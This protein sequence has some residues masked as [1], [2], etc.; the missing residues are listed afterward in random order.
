VHGQRYLVVTA[1]DYGIG[2][3]TSQGILD[4]ASSGLVTGSVLLVNSPYAEHAVQAWRRA[5]EPMELGWH[6]CLTLDRPLAPDGAVSSLVDAEGRFWTL[7]SFVRRLWLGQIRDAEIEQ[8]LRTQYGRCHDLLGRP[9]LLVNAH[10]HVQVFAAVGAI[11]RRVLRQ[12]TPLPYLRCV[13]EPWRTLATIPGARAK[14]TF[15]SLLGS[16]QARRQRQEQFPGNDW[17]A[18]VTDPRCV[19]DPSFLER[20]LKRMPGRVVELTCH[21]GYLDEKLVGRDCTVHDGLLERRIHELHL[22]RQPRFREACRHA[23]FALVPPSAIGK[24][25]ASP[26]AQAA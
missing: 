24:L 4:L 18:G 2:P 19:A 26:P 1:D 20:W 7:G 9:P 22:L 14:R 8:E 3:A 16:Q 23:G 13:A 5:G 17:L 10:H 6:P 21:P 15:L 25:L 12:F 11:L